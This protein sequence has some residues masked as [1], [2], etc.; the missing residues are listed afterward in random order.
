MRFPDKI[1]YGFYE[2]VDAGHGRIETRRCSILPARN[3]LM[4]ETFGSWRNLSTIVKIESI[5]EIKD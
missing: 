3:Y 1:P 2:E 4:E 5:R